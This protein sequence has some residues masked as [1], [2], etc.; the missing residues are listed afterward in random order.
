MPQPAISRLARLLVQ[1]VHYLRAPS[2]RHRGYAIGQICLAALAARDAELANA[3][4]S[5]LEE[6]PGLQLLAV[7]PLPG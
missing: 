4:R 7:G 6:L 5:R 3:A 1:A 2:V